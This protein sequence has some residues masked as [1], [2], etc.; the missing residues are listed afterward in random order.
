MKRIPI[1]FLIAILVLCSAPIYAETSAPIQWITEKEAALPIKET[2]EV[3]TN[4]KQPFDPYENVSNTEDIG[5]II[6]IEKPE[7]NTLYKDLI[8]ILVRLEKHP[9]G[10]P[11]N[12]ESLKIVY[13]KLLWN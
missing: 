13:L 12:M 10:D 11:I 4:N 3:K 8:D 6:K 5:P 2:K 9:L 7:E 1:G